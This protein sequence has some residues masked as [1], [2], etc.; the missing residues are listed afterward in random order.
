MPSTVPSSVAALRPSR[1]TL[2]GITHSPAEI[3]PVFLNTPQYVCEPLSQALGC[4]I[5]L[6]VETLNPIR[7]FK[8]RGASRFVR[9]FAAQHPG[10]TLVAAS[11]GN[12]GQAL[13]YACRA[14]RVPLVVFAATQA[15]PLKLQRMRSLGADL[16]LHG[17]DF[18]AAKLQAKRFVAD[19]AHGEAAP[20]MVEDGLDVLVTEGHGSIAIELTEGAA[21]SGEAIAAVLVPLGNGAMLSGIGCWFKAASPATQVIGVCAE[22]ATAMRDSWL[23]GPGAAVIEHPRVDT[24]ADGIAIRVPIPEA[25]ADMHGLVDDVVTVSDAQIVQ[26]MRL[27]HEH[28]GLVLEPSGAAGVA[29]LLADRERFAGRHVA[30]VLC[31]G[32]LTPEDARRWLFDAL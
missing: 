15:N 3:D 23:R 20:R 28:A 16:R 2:Q 19:H 4:R 5:T 7:S 25:V 1:I 13:A 32:N 10:V 21:R 27:V 18:D 24:I 31:G 9:H 12:W 30:C 8:G 26:A 6:K 29:A 11:A 22:G 17:S 14:H